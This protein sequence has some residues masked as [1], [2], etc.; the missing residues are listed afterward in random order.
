MIYPQLLVRMYPNPAH[1]ITRLEGLPGKG[2]LVMSN[3]QGQ[4]MYSST[5]THSWMDVPLKGLSPGM[6]S[7]RL[8]SADGTWQGKL[9]VR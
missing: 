8:L 6:Y 2:Y 1:E 9:I 4:I 5:V 7:I 3:L